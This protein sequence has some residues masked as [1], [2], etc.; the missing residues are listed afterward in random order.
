LRLT[1]QSL[2]NVVIRLPIQQTCDVVLVRE[3]LK[4]MKFVSRDRIRISAQARS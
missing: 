4:V 3:S 1:P 2:V